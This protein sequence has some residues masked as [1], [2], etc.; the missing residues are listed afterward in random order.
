MKGDLMNTNNQM[1]LWNEGLSPIL[2]FRRDFDRLLN[3]WIFPQ[4]TKSSTQFMPACDVEEYDDHYLL[5]LEMAGIR[6]EDLKM[7]VIENQ[8]LISGERKA[9]TRKKA[10]SQIYSERQY[11]KFQRAFTLPAGIDS[12]AVEANYQDGVLHIIVPKAESAKP[13]QIK[14]G[15]GSLGSRFSRYLNQPKEQS[16]EKEEHYSTNTEKVAS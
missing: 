5:N 6:K 7:E 14:I 9:E 16:K 3:D 12:S 8:I 10:D 4:S 11:G 2:D 15:S 1:K 13:K